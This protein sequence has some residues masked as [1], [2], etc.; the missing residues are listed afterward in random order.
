MSQ[1]VWMTTLLITSE[2]LPSSEAVL[3]EMRQ[4]RRN[5]RNST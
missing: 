2:S 5:L 3:N 1:A 4:T